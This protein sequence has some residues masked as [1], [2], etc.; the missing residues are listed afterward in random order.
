MNFCIS[1]RIQVRNHGES[2]HSDQFTYPIIANDVMHFMKQHSIEKG[3]MVGHSLGNLRIS[4]LVGH[5]HIVTDYWSWDL[6]D[7]WESAESR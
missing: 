4:F 5:C 2:P 1:P 7:S 3:V 6:W